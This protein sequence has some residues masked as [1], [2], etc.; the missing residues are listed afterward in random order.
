MLA[1]ELYHKSNNHFL[2]DGRSPNGLAA[3][4]LYFAA[5]LLGVNLLLSSIVRVSEFE[6]RS[7]CKDLLTSFKI[8]VNV[9]PLIQRSMVLK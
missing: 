7:R 3:S 8:T 1:A 2:A 5:I 4:Y 6:I 9:K